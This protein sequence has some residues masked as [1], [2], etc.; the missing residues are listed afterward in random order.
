MSRRVV[1]VDRLA[2]ALTGL[3]LVAAGL[4]LVLWW[5]RV[6]ASVPDT[7]DT[8]SV[9]RVL[10]QPWWPWALGAGGVLLLLIGV[11]WLLAHVPRRGTDRLQLPGTSAD[12]RLRAASDP[13]ARAA[14]EVLAATPGVRSAHGTVLRERGRVVATL[15]VLVE[16]GARLDELCAAADEVTAGLRQVLDRP[17]LQCSVRLKFARRG[18][19]MPRVS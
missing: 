7:V 10:A 18:R 17:D 19:R 13:V 15:S 14:A 1:L 4:A 3:L 5:T 16:P 11:R 2:A 12:G 8:G 9:R 6:P